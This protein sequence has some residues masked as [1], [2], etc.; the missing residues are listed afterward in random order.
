[1][2]IKEGGALLLTNSTHS[3]LRLAY[4]WPPPA[5]CLHSTPLVWP[6]GT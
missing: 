1:M 4:Y 5:E 6:P 3:C 2:R